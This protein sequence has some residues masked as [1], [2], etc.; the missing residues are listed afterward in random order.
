MENQLALPSVRSWLVTCDENPDRSIPVQVL[1]RK[2]IG[3][4]VESARLQPVSLPVLSFEFQLGVDCSEIG[5]LRSWFFRP[6]FSQSQAERFA[7]QR[8]PQPRLDLLQPCFARTKKVNGPVSSSVAEFFL[9]KYLEPFVLTL[10]KN[11]R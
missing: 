2:Q 3:H 5:R 6:L 10:R 11:C 8:L 4:P 9:S 1:F 7:S